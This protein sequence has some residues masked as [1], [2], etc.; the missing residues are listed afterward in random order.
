M[1]DPGVLG[2]Q[3][4]RKSA[5]GNDKVMSPT[6]CPTLKTGNIPGTSLC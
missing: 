1:M 6:H 4:S 3:I 5:H 2:T